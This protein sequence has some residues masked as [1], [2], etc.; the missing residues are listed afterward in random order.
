MIGC[1][2]ASFGQVSGYLNYASSH[3]AIFTVSHP[4][5][6]NQPTIETIIAVKF[7][8]LKSRCKTHPA[9]DRASSGKTSF[10]HFLLS[11]THVV[12]RKI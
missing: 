3:L 6:D 8:N 1:T 9:I 12:G 4:N 5:A 7:Q 11:T 2:L 10:G